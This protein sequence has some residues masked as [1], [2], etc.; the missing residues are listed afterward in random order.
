MFR[1]RS[2]VFW[3]IGGRSLAAGQPAAPDSHTSHG[4]VDRAVRES[5][6]QG[7]TTQSVIISVKPG[8]RDQLR[9]K[10]ALKKVNNIVSGTLNGGAAPQ[11]F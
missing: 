11:G 1:S 7:T 5:L 2:L 4:K 9:K 3:L 10:D 8:Y 6:R